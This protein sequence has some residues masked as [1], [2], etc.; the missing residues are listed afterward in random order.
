MTNLLMRYGRYRF[1]TSIGYGRTGFAACRS[2]RHG[3]R[4]ERESRKTHSSIWTWDLT[5]RLDL[6]R[7]AVTL[8]NELTAERT[9]AAELALERDDSRMTEETDCSEATEAREDAAADLR[10]RHY[11]SS[12]IF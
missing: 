8:E 4:G 6:E 1:D 7:S 11:I 12:L 9:L 10:G 3:L 2:C 5:L